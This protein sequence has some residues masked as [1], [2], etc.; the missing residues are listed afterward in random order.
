MRTHIIQERPVLAHDVGDSLAWNILHHSLLRS[1]SEY[2]IRRQL[3]IEILLAEQPVH[4][5]EK[6]D[7]ELILAHI[8]PVL[9]N[10]RILRSVGTTEIE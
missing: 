9:E 6:L 4:K 7:D 8:V 2:R 3:D 1:S 10:D 5:S